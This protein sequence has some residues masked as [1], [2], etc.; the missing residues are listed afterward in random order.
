M[1]KTLIITILLACACIFVAFKPKPAFKSR[2]EKP[3]T[4]FSF[5]SH[6]S[7]MFAAAQKK[8]AFDNFKPSKLEAWQ[9][10]F[11]KELKMLTGVSIIEQ[12]LQGYRPE[13]KKISSED[14]G[15]AI[16]ERW[17]IWTEPD[18]NLPFVMIV[19]KDIEG[20]VPLV[21]TPHGHGK[22]TEQY[23]G[24]YTSPEDSISAVDGQRNMA[25]LFA[26]KGY[27]TITPAARGFEGT[28]RPEDSKSVSSCL[29]LMKR[30]ALV[31]R[32]PVGDRVWDIMK[33]LDWALGALPV[34][35]D[36]VILTGN[37]GGGTQTVYAG[38]IDTRI[39]I[40]MP[41]SSFSS[42]E[43]SIGL[44]EHCACNYIP[45]IMNYGDMGDILGL[46]APRPLCIIQG[47][48]DP[49][50]PI[51][52]AKE[53]FETVKKVYAAAGA[54]DNCELFIGP[55]GHRYYFGGAEAFVAK[56]L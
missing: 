42:F 45:G 44:Q 17:Q 46:V 50:F 26:R 24:I 2:T 18:V 33:I 37:S 3:K 20:K 54:P 49:I 48:D 15:F 4:A 53:Q 34:D 16:R 9:K 55:E 23:A 31:G 12:Q 28:N 27:I 41:A 43:A 19:P 52:G 47:K 13:L 10:G 25:L 21:I 35:P 29:E 36:K 14:I 7:E 30:D 11:R 39:S 40:C 8:Y 32:T 5:N 1:K 51:D 6:C 38:A 22:N 56:H